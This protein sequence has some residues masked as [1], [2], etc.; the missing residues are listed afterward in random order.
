MSDP[1]VVGVGLIGHARSGKSTLARALSEN[2]PGS[3]VV[4][5]GDAVRARAESEG[6]D[7]EDRTVL[8]DLGQRWVSSDPEAFCRAVLQRAAQPH[9]L[10][11]IDGIRHTHI[12]E[13]LRELLRPRRLI[14]AYLR[15]PRSTLVARLAESG[16]SHEHADYLLN[17]PTE[18]EIDG[19]L[20]TMADI[21]VDTTKPP[22]DSAAA[23]RA[24]LGDQG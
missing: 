21:E 11:I 7:T 24:A 16:M 12:A 3:A 8:L 23:I 19:S 1:S 4:S 22:A 18:V 14:L 17:D 10:L 6:M 13:L 5:F 2:I 15:L 9:T 20:R